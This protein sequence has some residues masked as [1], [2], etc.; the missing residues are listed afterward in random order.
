MGMIVFLSEKSNRRVRKTDTKN[1]AVL[2]ASMGIEMYY[3]SS[4]TIQYIT[5]A[6]CLR[7]KQKDGT[8]TKPVAA[9]IT[10]RIVKS[11]QKDTGVYLRS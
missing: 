4:D 6:S 5:A 3:L 1:I 9:A 8:S 7:V 11:K 10:V 2:G